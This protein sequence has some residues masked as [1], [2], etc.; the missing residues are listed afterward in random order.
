MNTDDLLRFFMLFINDT[1]G[2]E[3]FVMQFDK[4]NEHYTLQIRH[5]ERLLDLHKTT[6]LPGGNKAYETLFQVTFFSL[7]RLFAA[8][9]KEGK[10]LE[11]A[12]N[13]LDDIERE[14]GAR[15]VNPGWLRRNFME[16][17]DAD[18]EKLQG[19]GLLRTKNRGRQVRFNKNYGGLD[20]DGL[21]KPIHRAMEPGKYI[22]L[23]WHRGG[24]VGFAGSLIVAPGLPLRFFVVPRK[25]ANAI[26]KR[27]VLLL[28]QEFGRMEGHGVK[29]LQTA[30]RKRF[31]M[32][33]SQ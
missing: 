2:R 22:L 5:R 9:R 8:L 6:K 13:T 28:M 20:V 15:F 25:A 26:A 23:K 14:L 19:V 24:G 18:L 4:P 27:V 29:D 21:F 32:L 31:P 7:L 17:M 30:L 16:A 12:L 10:R 1:E 11:A 33:Q 3:T